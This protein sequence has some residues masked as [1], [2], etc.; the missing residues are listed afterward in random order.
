ME[1]REGKKVAARAGSGSR[2]RLGGYF[3]IAADIVGIDMCLLFYYKLCI[4]SWKEN[5]YELNLRDCERCTEVY[6]IDGGL[7]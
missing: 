2:R 7:S 3:R 5:L 6:T 1:G 4:G